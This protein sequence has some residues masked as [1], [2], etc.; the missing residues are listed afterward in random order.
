MKSNI[1]VVLVTVL[2]V[3]VTRGFADDLSALP[4]VPW[5][6][7]D[8][9]G[10]S[11]PTT[12]EVGPPRSDRFVGIF[13]FLW[14]S[15]P[16]GRSPNWDGPYDITKILD[17]DPAALSKPDSPLWGGVGQYHYWG[18]PL[19]GYYRSDDPWVLRR[20]A[21]ALA[22]AG[23]DTLIF[24]TTNAQTYPETYMALCKVFQQVRAEGGSTPQISFMVNTKAGQ[25]AARIYRDLYQ[26]GQ[27]RELW[28]RWQ[29]KPLMICDPAEASPEL[30]EFFTLRRA[31][32]PF[33]M[34]NTQ[35]AWHWEA[36]YPQP[37]G[38]VDD[39]AKPEQVNVSVAQN[40]RCSDG[41]VTNM[42]EGDARGRSF[43]NGAVDT[44]L[45]AVNFGHNFQEQWQRVFELEPPFVMITGWNEWIAGRWQRPG[46]PIVFVD[47]YD[48]EHSRD[49]EFARVGHLDH[50]Y[51]QMVANIRRYKGAP[52][53]PVSSG[54]KT[55]DIQSGFEQWEDV[56]P[57]YRDHV[58]ETLPRDHAG[59]AGLHYDNRS[60]RNDLVAGKV[61][62]DAENVY[63]YLRTDAPIRPAPTPDGLWL[64][65]DSDR[66][67][68][69]GWEGYD[70]IVGRHIDADGRPWIERNSAGWQWDK[71]APVTQRLEG[72]RLH[73]ALPRSSLGQNSG[74]S[75]DFK[76]VDNSQAPGD[77]LDFYL[78]GD[79]APDGRFNFRYS[80][81]D[82]ARP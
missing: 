61:A 16:A 8:G 82:A 81:H 76:W 35:K 78:S 26:K 69:T 24:D 59:V 14:H 75:F 66:N 73:L 39:P 53:L 21:Q 5:P 80:G 51:W 52:E 4:G 62:H 18:E 1:L 40:L 2:S 32:W 19:Y 13:Y 15:A 11:L 30:N 10:R 17:R 71:V 58:G 48:E 55:I 31:H 12:D 34:V 49:I 25:S 56:A 6:A 38:Y 64:L 37:Y 33:T 45:G 42:S 46:Q 29:G 36:T 74:A 43:H 41:R 65:I 54:P 67:H 28:F 7:T 63:F 27:Y 23:V 77:I 68:D 20:H 22:D 9:L 57:E 70:L 72:S 44:A 47:Q 60:G 3:S 79:V 50:Y